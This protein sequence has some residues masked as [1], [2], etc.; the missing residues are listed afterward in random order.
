MKL[1]KIIL[2]SLLIASVV[3]P[4]TV[5][6]CQQSVF[7]SSQPLQGPMCQ[8][9]QLQQG[10]LHLD[11]MKSIS[12]AILPLFFTI[13]G[14]I[15][16]YAQYKLFHYFP[17]SSETL[18]EYFKRQASWHKRSHDELVSAFAHGKIHRMHFD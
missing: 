10:I 5:S 15:I 16:I 11:Y 9:P 14:L 6:G 7:A 8:Y 1:S 3:L 4:Y 17:I 18:I 12:T 2:I 13:L